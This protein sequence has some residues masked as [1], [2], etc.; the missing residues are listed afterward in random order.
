MF[1]RKCGYEL[2][3]E[4]RFCRRCGVPVVNRPAREDINPRRTASLP[5][6]ETPFRNT[7]FRAQDQNERP[8][9]LPLGQFGPLGQ[10]RQAPPEPPPNRRPKKPDQNIAQ[11]VIKMSARTQRD[12]LP[13]AKT[14]HAK[15][16]IGNQ[17]ATTPIS[18][19]LQQEP[20]AKPFFTQALTA[21]KSPQHK[22]LIAV[23]PLLLLAVLLLFIF[24]YIAGR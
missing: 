8:T 16:V 10:P 12:L 23:V 15:T 3:S 20:E 18:M 2:R 24:A 21:D 11:D 17:P 14:S 5:R 6:N 4:A 22:R 9:V 13:P 7:G 19:P 1:C